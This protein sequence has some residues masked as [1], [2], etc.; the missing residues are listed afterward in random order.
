MKLKLFF[1]LLI[2]TMAI[3]SCRVT[4]QP[5]YDAGVLDEIKVGQTLTQKLYETAIANPDKSY[6]ASDSLY[7]MLAAQISSIATKEA[8]RV[9]ST[10]LVAQVNELQ[11]TFNKYRNSH[12]SKNV[13]NNTEFGL[14]A[15][16]L[17]AIWK[18]IK[19]A[20]QNLPK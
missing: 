18:S 17:D 6:A 3:A 15:S 13:L 7:K 4:F 5:T 8:A 16:Y 20:E 10:L 2:I 14:Y 12:Q 11:K 19:N 1:P 9:K